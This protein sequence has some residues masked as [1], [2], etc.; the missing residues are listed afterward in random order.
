[1]L[2]SVH[3]TGI[4]RAKKKPTIVLMCTV[5]L[6]WSFQTLIQFSLKSHFAMSIQTLL[7]ANILSIKN[8]TFYFFVLST[9]L[10]IGDCEFLQPLNLLTHG[11]IYSV[12]DTKA[13]E[14]S[15][16]CLQ[17]VT[18]SWKQ[19]IWKGEDQ[20]QTHI[21]H[22]NIWLEFSRTFQ[23][24]VAITPKTKSPFS[25]RYRTEGFIL[26]KTRNNPCSRRKS[27]LGSR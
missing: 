25:T 9:V 10:I 12:Q 14:N 22:K 24:E 13:L 20:V 15:E 27:N 11:L 5:Y 6:C 4:L 7:K 3:V 19:R 23:L 21:F 16:C 8:L 1:M 26:C 2:T 17:A 18:M